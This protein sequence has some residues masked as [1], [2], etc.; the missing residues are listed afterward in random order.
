MR[1]VG[2]WHPCLYETCL[3]CNVKIRFC[4]T[5]VLFVCP[6]L[7]WSCWI[8]IAAWALHFLTGSGFG[9]RHSLL[10]A[11]VRLG[12]SSWLICSQFFL[13]AWFQLQLLPVFVLPMDLFT[14][15]CL[16]ATV[17]R[18]FVAMPGTSP[19]HQLVESSGA[20][21]FFRF[22]L[23]AHRS[24]MLGHVFSRW[25]HWPE[26][27]FDLVFLASSFLS[28]LGARR[29]QPPV[30][31]AVFLLLVGLLC[32]GSCS[33]FGPQNCVAS[34]HFCAKHLPSLVHAWPAHWRSS[35]SLQFR[36]LLVMCVDCC[37]I[38]SRL[39]SWATGPKISRVLSLNHF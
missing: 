1:E 39:C 5:C 8:W 22:G 26:L 35:F 38:S 34:V 14:W 32:F 4:Y 33:S 20:Q 23:C 16:R 9:F 3:E 19:V 11:W 13:H 30:S 24:S 37:M 15:R 2:R 17:P 31:P 27:V 10:S 7:P 25:V 12:I 18:S 29:S 21:W 6:R 36:F 28:R